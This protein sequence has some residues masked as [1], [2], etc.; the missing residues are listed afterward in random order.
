MKFQQI[1][2]T[3]VAVVRSP[4]TAMQYVQC[5][6][7]FVDDVMLSHNGANEPESKKTRMLRRV[8]LQVAAPVT[9]SAVSDCILFEV[10]CSNNGSLTMT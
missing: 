8:R 3:L 1:L 6:S 2:C 7:S 5:I 4:L 10:W 9:K